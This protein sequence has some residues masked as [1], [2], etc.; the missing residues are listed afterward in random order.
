M[1]EII[2]LDYKRIWRKGVEYWVEAFDFYPYVVSNYGRIGNSKTG[3]VLRQ[4]DSGWGYFQVML[5]RDGK[6][7]TKSVH[8]L[9]AESF[10]GVF[11]LL[12]VNHV[13]GDKHNNRLWNLEWVTKGENNKH[14]I[15]IGLRN[16]HG[17]RVRIVELDLVFDSVK[18]CGAYFGKHPNGVHDV[19]KGR[20][21][22]YKGY[23][24]EYC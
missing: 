21:A 2:Q 7:H 9:I 22:T 17:K 18:A 13:D 4:R 1:N 23:T 12:E 3:L 24:F 20:A 16:P 10:Y 19:L 6:A 14:A 15:D 8:R 5:W 11:P